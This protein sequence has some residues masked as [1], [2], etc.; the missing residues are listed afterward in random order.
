MPD[1]LFELGTEEMP[2][3]EIPRLG[4]G[5]RTGVEAVSYTHLTLPTICSV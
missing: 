3:L 5:L 1:L 2:A 4:E